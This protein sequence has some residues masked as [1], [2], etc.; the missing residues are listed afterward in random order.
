[1]GQGLKALSKNLSH[2]DTT[3]SL[4]QSLHTARLNGTSDSILVL[5]RVSQHKIFEVLQLCVTNLHLPMNI[6]LATKA[7]LLQ[8][9]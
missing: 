3:G 1:M 5:F 6:S 2:K 8:P 9:F 7:Y 4:V